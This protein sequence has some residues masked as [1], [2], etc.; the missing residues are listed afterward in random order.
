MEQVKSRL[1]LQRI[2][3]V[4]MEQVKSCIHVTSEEWFI[5]PQLD[6]TTLG[7]S[8][9]AESICGQNSSRGTQTVSSG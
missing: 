9:D 5:S 2:T 4:E 8:L 7:T 6:S 3:T 1:N